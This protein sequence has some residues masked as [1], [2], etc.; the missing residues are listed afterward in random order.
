MHRLKSATVLTLLSG[1][2]L[3]PA[4]GPALTGQEVDPYRQGQEWRD[5]GSWETALDVWEAAADAFEK[6]IES[7]AEGDVLVFM[8]GGYEISRTVEAIVL[9]KR[10]LAVVIAE[11]ERQLVGSAVLTANGKET[12]T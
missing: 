11:A 1:L 6:A 4:L 12:S 2:F 5:V 3:S 8:P 10:I 7:G 9:F